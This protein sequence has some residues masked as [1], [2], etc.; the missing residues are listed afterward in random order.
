MLQQKLKIKIIIKKFWNSSSRVPCEVLEFMEL[1]L[2]KFK[3]NSSFMNS[4]TLHGTQVYGTRVPKKKISKS[5]FAITRYFK[6]QVSE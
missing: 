3:W 1:E 4:S 2:K 6:N 5:T